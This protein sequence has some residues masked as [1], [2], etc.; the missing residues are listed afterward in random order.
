METNLKKLFLVNRA[1]E[2]AYERQRYGEQESR[3]QLQ[4]IYEPLFQFYDKRFP[5]SFDS[6][7]N[8]EYE[9]EEQEEENFHKPD[10]FLE[11][12]KIESP[13]KSLSVEEFSHPS[14][15]TSTNTIYGITTFEEKST[16]YS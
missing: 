3:Y 12:D 2:L 1:L 6:S 10:Y 7:S 11:D 14:S 4:K 15:I 5:S 13:Q 8:K 16:V 9:Q